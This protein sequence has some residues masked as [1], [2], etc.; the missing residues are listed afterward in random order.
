MLYEFP[1][2]FWLTLMR[3]NLSFSLSE[4]VSLQQFAPSDIITQT[5][6]IVGMPW[7]M[8]CLHHDNVSL[9]SGSGMLSRLY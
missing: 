6:N 4:A 1:F 5:L 2:S 8:F 9:R 7:H 3:W